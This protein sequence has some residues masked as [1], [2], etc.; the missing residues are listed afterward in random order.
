MKLP[1]WLLVIVRSGFR[2]TLVISLAVSFEVLISLPPETVTV[3]VTL[4]GAFLA[5]LTVRVTGK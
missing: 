2:V 3:L 1:V 5:T 4:A